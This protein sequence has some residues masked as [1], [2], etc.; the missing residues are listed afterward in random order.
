MTTLSH[1]FGESQTIT[2][3]SQQK[4]LLH[5]IVKQRQ[6]WRRKDF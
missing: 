4:I 6:K 5:Q 3:L 2:A 1:A